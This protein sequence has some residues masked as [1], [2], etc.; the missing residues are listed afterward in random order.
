[1]FVQIVVEVL[2]EEIHDELTHRQSGLDILRAELGLGLRLEYG[3]GDLDRDRRD[4]RGA[5]VGRIV[6]LVVELL[7]RL[8]HRLA[9]R[10]LMRTS[11]RRILAVDERIVRLAVARAVRYDHFDVVAREVHGLVERLVRDVVV[12]KIEQSVLRDI[13][14]A[15]ERY[16]QAEVEIG[17]VLDHLLDILHV[18]GVVAEYLSVD[19]EAYVC[20]GRL[21]DTRLA[22]V[23]K[24]DALR[25]CYRA[26]LAVAHRTRREL[27]RKHVDGLDADAVKTHCLLACLAAVLA[28]GVHLAH[29]SRERFERYAA[30]V[31]A[32]PHR[33]VLDRDLDTLAGT[34]DELVDRVVDDLFQ[35]HVYAV[36][37]LR[38]VA[39]LADIHSR[40]QADMLARRE[41]LY[42][43]VVVCRSTVFL[44][45]HISIVSFPLLS[46][47]MRRP[48]R[49]AR[50]PSAPWYRCSA[51]ARPLSAA[52]SLSL[53]YCAS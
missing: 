13:G 33:V 22:A 7:D 40:A 12:D 41:R 2:S 48:C 18:V 47:P 39:Q 28:A 3:V 32:H 49:R 38:A 37:R 24:L 29:G 44:F 35:K 26:R 17:V 36:V 42:R 4:D 20:S 43:V 5:N 45:C 34:H 1:M 19:A 31:V 53:W 27:A 9:E 51:L 52:I 8:G 30:A 23:G 16:R 6:I 21:A 25:E 11:L 15:V 50:R 10:R 46:R 14:L